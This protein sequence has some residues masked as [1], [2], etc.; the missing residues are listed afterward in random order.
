MVS[1]SAKK[2][3]TKM[4]CLCTFKWRKSFFP[5]N[6][7]MVDDRLNTS[8]HCQDSR[9]GKPSTASYTPYSLSF[10]QQSRLAKSCPRQHSI[11][12]FPTKPCNVFCFLSSLPLLSQPPRQCLSLTCHLSILNYHC[13]AGAGLPIHM[14]GEVSWEPRRRPAWAS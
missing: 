7:G 2:V 6:K 4:S 10:S 8:I 11:L 1:V 9:R 5:K 3:T 12:S 13:I 14:I